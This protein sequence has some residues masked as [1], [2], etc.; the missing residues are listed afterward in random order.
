MLSAYAKFTKVITLY[1]DPV[2]L[3]VACLLVIF[4]VNDGMTGVN[5]TRNEEPELETDLI[6]QSWEHILHAS[7]GALKISKCFTYMVFFDW[8]DGKYHLRKPAEIDSRV[9]FIDSTSLAEH[10]LECVNPAT[11][12]RTIGPA[13]NWNEED[14]F[15]LGQSGEQHVQ[16]ITTITGHLCQ[17]GGVKNMLLFALRWTQLHAGVS[18]PIVYKL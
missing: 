2:Q 7:G 6:A 3:I 14:V 12:R 17:P 10:A 16:R 13:G 18:F 4:F 15:R 1:Y 8:T 11:G 5:D 9:T